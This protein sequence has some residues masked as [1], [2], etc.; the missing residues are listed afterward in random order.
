[1][2][3]IDGQLDP[4]GGLALA[5]PLTTVEEGWCRAQT[6]QSIAFGVGGIPIHPIID[7][8]HAVIAPR[9]RR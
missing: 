1:M 7:H 5:E 9:R 8:H 6:A 2:P 3:G 4:P